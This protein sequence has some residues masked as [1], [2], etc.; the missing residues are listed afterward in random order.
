MKNHWIGKKFHKLT[1]IEVLKKRKV[2]CICDCGNKVSVF[3]NN[4]TRTNPNTTSCGCVHKKFMRKRFEDSHKKTGTRIYRIWTNMKT[5]CSNSKS[6]KYKWYGAR[7][8][9]VCKSWENFVNFYHDMGEP[10]T[11]KHTL[12]RI[13]NNGNYS[14]K[15]CKWSTMKEQCKNRR[16]KNMAI[17]A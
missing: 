6:D 13:D 14:M 17:A 11:D 5:R 15:N 3:L 8:I 16:P 1:I 12:D 4:I 10:P 7:G 2:M 9:T